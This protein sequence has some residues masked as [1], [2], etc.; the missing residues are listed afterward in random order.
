[1]INTYSELSERAPL[2]WSFVEIISGIRVAVTFGIIEFRSG[3]MA[4]L[5]FET[6]SVARHLIW[7]RCCQKQEEAFLALFKDGNLNNLNLADRIKIAK[8]TASAQF[9]CERGHRLPEYTWTDMLVLKSMT[10]DQKQD[11]MTNFGDLGYEIF[12]PYQQMRVLKAD[13]G[14]HAQDEYWED[15]IAPHT[16]EEHRPESRIGLSI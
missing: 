3:G 1:M 13:L 11:W 8:F 5:R 6:P 15:K 9:L 16:P 4:F 12:T 7:S 10:S 14:Y 2:A